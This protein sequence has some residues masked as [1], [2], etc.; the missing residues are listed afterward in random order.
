[1][2]APLL[3]ASVALL[4]HVCTCLAR[5]ARLQWNHRAQREAIEPEEQCERGASGEARSERRAESERPAT[6]QGRRRERPSKLAGP[7]GRATVR[8]SDQTE[9]PGQR[10]GRHERSSGRISRVWEG[11]CQGSQDRTVWG[12][13][14][15]MPHIGASRS[16]YNRIKSMYRVEYWMHMSAPALFNTAGEFILIGS[17]DGH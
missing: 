12:P 11:G 10:A 13:H 17:L 15:S 16:S 6:G 2:R 14:L 7:S 9:P 8:P 1:M 3:L 5:A 4:T